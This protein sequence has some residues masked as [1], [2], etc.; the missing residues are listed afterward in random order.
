MKPLLSCILSLH[1]RCKAVAQSTFAVLVLRNNHISDSEASY[2]IEVEENPTRGNRGAEGIIHALLQ[3]VGSD[4][5]PAAAVSNKLLKCILMSTVA[6]GLEEAYK[7]KD[8]RG[9][10]KR[11][12]LAIEDVRLRLW[13]G[14]ES[15]RNVSLC[16][17]LL[18]RV[19]ESAIGSLSCEPSFHI[20]FDTLSVIAASSNCASSMLHSSSL[21]DAGMKIAEI[22]VGQRLAFE[23]YSSIGE[24]SLH[25]SPIR[26]E[27]GYA[28]ETADSRFYMTPGDSRGGDD[29]A[30]RGYF[31]AHQTAAKNQRVEQHG[32]KGGGASLYAFDFDSLRLGGSSALN[33][34]ERLAG[35]DGRGST[36]SGVKN[37]ARRDIGKISSDG[38]APQDDRVAIKFGIRGSDNGSSTCVATSITLNACTFLM[39]LAA[40]RSG[41]ETDHVD[42]MRRRRETMKANVSI[43]MKNMVS[44]ALAHAL[45][46]S[47]SKE[48]T[49]N[50]LTLQALVA[51]GGGFDAANLTDALFEY[52]L[53]ESALSRENMEKARAYDSEL[54]ALSQ[55]LRTAKEKQ[56]RAEYSLRG[57]EISW[58]RELAAARSKATADASN[59]AR[60]HGSARDDAEKKLAETQKRVQELEGEREDLERRLEETQLELSRVNASAQTALADNLESQQKALAM[61]TSLW[62]E[63]EKCQRFTEELAELKK[64]G[65]EEIDMINHFQRQQGLIAYINQLSGIGDMGKVGP[66]P[67]DL[68]KELAL[69]IGEGIGGDI[70][71]GRAALT[72]S[73]G[74]IDNNSNGGDRR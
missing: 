15:A 41:T 71:E 31:S 28:A 26:A 13:Y 63:K 38:S 6:P 58:E 35:E 42:V 46:Q 50:A 17:K 16:K 21:A 23:A 60:F 2:R 53:S 65:T 49:Q 47:Y 54:A 36:D 29:S 5:S 73:V 25:L 67:E 33:L 51:R 20:I 55:E 10:A 56:S 57:K 22:A 43:A 18:K 1:Q 66:P 39:R 3:L 7:K 45:T 11:I 27:Q 70:P 32:G 34:E 52:C 8:D 9:G 37:S 69:G 19:T 72:S 48:M 40:S 61:E 74:D 14:C 62:R 24:R 4:Y 44:K 64:K 30:D 59:M 12:R 68:M